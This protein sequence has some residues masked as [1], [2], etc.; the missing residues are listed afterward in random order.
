[1]GP[2]WLFDYTSHFK[3]INVSSD[4]SSGSSSSSKFVSEDEDEEVIY[5]PPTVT[6]LPPE[7]ESFVPLDSPKSPVQEVT[8]DA[9]ATPLILV[10]R[11]FMS[12]DAS[13]FTSIFMELLFPEKIANE[14]VAESSNV[15][16][17]ANDGV[18]NIHNLPVS[19]NGIS[20]DIP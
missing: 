6:S 18:V 17:S 15:E 10:E 4:S 20:Q 9:D 13:A 1:M 19:L 7:G 11:D 12:R 2:N 8:P 14:F 3:S 5:R 16:Q